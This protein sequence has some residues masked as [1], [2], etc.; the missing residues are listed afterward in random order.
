V[1]SIGTKITAVMA[2]HAQELVDL[3]VTANGVTSAVTPADHFVF[4]PPEIDSV[5][6][7]EGSL[8]EGTQ[9]KIAGSNF[10]GVGQVQLGNGAVISFGRV[11]VS[12]DGHLLTFIMGSRPGRSNRMAR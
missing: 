2:P 11:K 7:S 8:A 3:T 1:N 10:E 9:V 12:E 4:G 6:T 5:L